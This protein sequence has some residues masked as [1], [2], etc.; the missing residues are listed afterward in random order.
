MDQLPDLLLR[1]V[2]VSR[3]G[4]S[5][6]A[7]A[8][9][10]EQLAIRDA[11][12]GLLAGKVARRRI[13]AFRQWTTTV[14]LDAVTGNTALPAFPTQIQLPPRLEYLAICRQGIFSGKFF[15]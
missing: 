12:N 2:R 8:N 1:I 10:P 9:G 4:R 5:R 6:R 7:V 15:C 14:S 13:K 3:H 11:A